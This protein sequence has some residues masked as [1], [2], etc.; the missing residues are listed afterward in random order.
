MAYGAPG[1]EQDDRTVYEYTDYVYPADLRVEGEILYA[2]VDGLGG[3]FGR[4]T[5]LIV[6]DLSA[7]KKLRELKVD[8]TDLKPPR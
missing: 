4:H 2:L 3:W 1:D 5:K 6:Y 8:P 7:R